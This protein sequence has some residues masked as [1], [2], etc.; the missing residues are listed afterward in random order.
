[1]PHINN[2]ISPIKNPFSGAFCVGV[3]GAAL[4][5]IGAGIREHH[6]RRQLP[7]PEGRGLL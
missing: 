3:I 2:I 6:L 1:M 4:T 7:R 5:C